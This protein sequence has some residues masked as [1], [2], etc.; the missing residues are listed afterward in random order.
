MSPGLVATG[1]A[2]PSGPR[3]V[4]AHRRGDL[5]HGARNVAILGFETFGFFGAVVFHTFL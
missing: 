2:H 1:A 3:V 5:W 4:G